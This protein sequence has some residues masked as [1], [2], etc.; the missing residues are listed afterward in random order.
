MAVGQRRSTAAISLSLA[1]LIALSAPPLAGQV[2]AQASGQRG[3]ASSQAA[4]PG[5]SDE[6]L[7]KLESVY[8]D[9]HA[10]PELAMGERRTAR[11][12]ARLAPRAGIRG[13]GGRGRNRRG[14]A[15]P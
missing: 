10:N 13:H 14:G 5:P 1:T 2:F 6:L 4:F 3:P 7:A 11:I 9:I 15:S 8:K 12:A